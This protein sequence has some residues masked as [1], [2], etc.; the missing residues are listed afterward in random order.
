MKTVKYAF[1]IGLLCVAPVRAGEATSAAASDDV[2]PVQ[3]PVD[4]SDLVAAKAA[5]YR[6]LLGAY[7]SG[8]D[9]TAVADSLAA[10][11]SAYQACHDE[12]LVAKT[13]SVDVS[14][15]T[16]SSDAAPA[17]SPAP[18]N[19]DV[20]PAPVPT[21]AASATPAVTDVT[22]ATPASAA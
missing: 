13:R 17:D 19:S 8:D 15:D 9:Q 1:A 16:A 11:L 6:T 12:K 21:D 20:S 10:L 18:S 5:A 2:A 7:K 22:P 4:C 14:S 3:I